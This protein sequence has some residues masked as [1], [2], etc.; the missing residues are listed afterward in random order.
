RRSMQAASNQTPSL[1]FPKQQDNS[2]E[3]GFTATKR[4]SFGAKIEFLIFTLGGTTK[5][6]D[7][8]QN[9]VKINFEAVPNSEGKVPRII[10]Q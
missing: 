3:Y 4:K 2:I 5:Q 10:P 9:T 1:G 6:T 8:A 7:T